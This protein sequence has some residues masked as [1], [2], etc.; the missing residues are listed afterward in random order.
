MVFVLWNEPFHRPTQDI[1]FAAQG[2]GGPD[3]IVPALHHVCRI[4]APDG[5]VFGADHM[6]ASRI[7]GATDEGGIRIRFPATVDVARVT[8]QVDIGFGDSIQPPPA[9]AEFPPLLDTVAS[10]VLAY[11]KEAMVSEKLRAAIAHGK[12]TSRYK[13]FFDLYFVARRFHFEGVRLVRA[14]AAT[15]EGRPS[16]T[17]DIPLPLATG[18]YTDTARGE[19]WRSPRGS[20]ADRGSPRFSRAREAMS[21]GPDRQRADGPDRPVPGSRNRAVA[22]RL[23]L[24]LSDA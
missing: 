2:T 20:P 5:V 13:D 1:D 18:F 16:P 7:R 22:R 6:T 24:C 12:Q 19:R 14:F 4:A 23:A 11:P 21:E 8:V 9:D 17:G 3:D 10:R 15:L